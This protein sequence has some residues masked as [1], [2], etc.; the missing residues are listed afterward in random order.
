MSAERKPTNLRSTC[1]KFSADEWD[2]VTKEREAFRLS[3]PK[4]LKSAYFKRTIQVYMMSKEQQDLFFAQLNIVRSQLDEMG[5]LTGA[6]ANFRLPL[7]LENI[8]TLLQKISSE[9]V[10]YQLKQIY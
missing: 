2:R 7:L 8:K 5:R 1:V 4:L 10:H 3:I 9:L 6:P